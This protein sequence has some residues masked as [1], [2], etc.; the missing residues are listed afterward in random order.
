MLVR[1]WRVRIAGTDG[2]LK[3]SNSHATYRR[4]AGARGTRGSILSGYKGH[5]QLWTRTPCL[6]V[7]DPPSVVLRAANLLSDSRSQMCLHSAAYAGGSL[8]L[9][10]QALTFLTDPTYQVGPI[11]TGCANQC[12]YLRTVSRQGDIGPPGVTRSLV[13]AVSVHVS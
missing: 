12:R 7:N 1:S 4:E 6:R 3:T 13:V 5:S 10:E 11:V 9:C 2:V 8:L